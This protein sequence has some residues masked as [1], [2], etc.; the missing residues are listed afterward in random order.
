MKK[1]KISLML[2][3]TAAVVSCESNTYQ[4]VSIETTNPTYI[5]NIKPIMTSN[6]TSCHSIDGGQ[7]PYLETYDQVKDA[8]INGALI[9]EIEAPSGQGMPEIGRMSQPKIDMINY[10]VSNG[11]IN[12]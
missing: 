7:T 12:Q 8:V 3:T 1:I 10:W 9:Q 6:C 11:F 4:E 5:A 2:L